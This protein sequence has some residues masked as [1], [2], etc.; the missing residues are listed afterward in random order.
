[1]AR[2]VLDSSL[3]CARRTAAAAFGRWGAMRG[4][5]AGSGGRAARRS[6]PTRAKAAPALL[7]GFEIALHAPATTCRRLDGLA[8]R[9]DLAREAVLPGFQLVEPFEDGLDLR[10]GV[11]FL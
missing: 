4:A 9:G 1:M 6:H 2:N 11:F 3:P 10:V 5:R 8:Q 7:I